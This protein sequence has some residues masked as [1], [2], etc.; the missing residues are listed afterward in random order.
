MI[1]YLEGEIIY[2]DEKFI[3]VK[4]NSIG[5]QIFISTIFSDKIRKEKIINLKLYTHLY[6][7]EGA[8]ELY[9]FA[10]LE[11]IDFFKTLLGVSGIGPRMALHI[12]S[13]A[14][15]ADIKSAIIKGQPEFLTRVSGVGKKTAERVVM[16]LRYKIDKTG[17]TSGIVSLAGEDEEVIEALMRL[18]YRSADAREA[19][20]QIPENLKNSSE[21]L[22]AALRFLGK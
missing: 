13:L 5:W 15:L 19:L 11:E 9:G 20:R 1:S 16:E 6:V 17:I 8:L 18:G 21:K 12:L 3:I 22:K 4:S 14:S 10:S 7:R 2:Q